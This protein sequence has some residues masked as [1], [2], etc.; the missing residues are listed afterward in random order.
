[1]RALSKVV[2][3][4]EYRLELMLAISGGERV[5]TLGGLA[6]LLG[7]SPSS[8]QM[9]FHALVAAGL[10]QPVRSNDSRRKF[11]QAAPSAAWQWAAE[12]SERLKIEVLDAP[13]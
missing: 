11:Y 9:P 13:A 4:Q 12:M 7:V 10:L 6:T 8:I 1:M 3:G 5:V 2:F